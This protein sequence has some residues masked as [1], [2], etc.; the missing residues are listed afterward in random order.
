[1]THIFAEVTRSLVVPETEGDPEEYSLCGRFSGSQSSGE[2][3]GGFLGN[4]G[5][6]PTCPDG[7]CGGTHPRRHPDIM[8]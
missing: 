8:F 1:M 5:C 6:S 4:P 3:K 7:E 2:G